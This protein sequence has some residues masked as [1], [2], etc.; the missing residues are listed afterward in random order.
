MLGEKIIFDR[1]LFLKGYESISI[2][3]REPYEVR[4]A[5]DILMYK[6]KFTEIASSTIYNIE[7][8]NNLNINE[9]ELAVIYYNTNLKRLEVDIAEE[10]TEYDSDYYFSDITFDID[11]INVS[12]NDLLHF[13][14]A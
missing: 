2:I 11:E 1:D 6:Y 7:H 12:D 13:L 8:C 4:E 10:Y 5:V 9:N 14:N 3:C